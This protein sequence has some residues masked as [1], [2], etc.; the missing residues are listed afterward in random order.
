MKTYLDCIP[1]FMNQ[2]LRVG[3]LSTDNE[4]KIKEILDNIGMLIKEIPMSLSP[5]EIAMQVY[6]EIKRITGNPD[7]FR[8]EK[9]QNIET[10]LKLYP[11]MKE[12]IKES[13]DS[14][15]KAVQIAIAGNVIDLGVNKTFDIEEDIL[16]SLSEDLTINDYSKLR[17][18]IIQSD[19]ILYIG[20]NSGEAVFDKLLIEEIDKPV[21]FVVRE[22]PVI[23]D[24]TKQ[25][26]VEA[27]L[28]KVAKIIS[29]GTSAPGNV[30]F[31][32]TQD[33]KEVFENAEMIIS[34]G[35][36]NYEALSGV[37][38]TIFFL[39]KAKCH[40]IAED[41]GVEEGSLILMENKKK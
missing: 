18:K 27:G 7:P 19:R 29:S 1:C 3:R 32:C 34:K 35:Q 12:I 10:A 21:T 39:L 14:L 2:A 17:E 8:K 41:I 20:D 36:G 15:L 37:D 33:F 40:V 30:L 25:E 24:V 38:A 4:D 23:N 28:D 6:F 9:K 26:A 13:E 5:P 11:R 16:K 22:N 31:T